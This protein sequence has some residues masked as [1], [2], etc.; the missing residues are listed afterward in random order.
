[1]KAIERLLGKRVIIR[2]DRAGVFYGTLSEAEPCGDKYTV[3]LTNVR[4]LWYWDGAA[5][6]TQLSEEGVTRPDGCKFTMWQD[7][8]V[9]AGVIEFHDV[10]KKAQE[11]IENV[12][13][14]KRQK[15]ELKISCR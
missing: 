10:K 15:K 2:S 9:V 14:W 11:V 5:S 8:L 1:M 6:L 4:R 3:G 7:S 12:R 13:I